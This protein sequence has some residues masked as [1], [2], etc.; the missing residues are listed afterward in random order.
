LREYT[1]EREHL[2]KLVGGNTWLFGEEFAITLNEVGLTTAVAELTGC[3]A[4]SKHGIVTR[5][6][7]RSGRLDILLPRVARR[8]VGDGEL[9]LI[10]ELK[11]PSH[12]LAMKDYLQVQSYAN[13]LSKHRLFVGT[14]TRWRFWLI[15]GSI[16]DD[17]K[18]QVESPDRE[19]GCAHR[20]ENGEIWV[21]GWGQVIESNLEVMEFY[22][23]R[24]DLAASQD[25]I[26]GKLDEMY[27]K[28]LPAG[29]STEMRPK[30]E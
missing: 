14:K 25:D 9:H 28:V 10:V 1:K 26:R 17:L 16:S 20:F 22:R 5:N 23:S 29:D 4:D 15:G 19:F 21:K 3:H 6:D 13:A 8:S 30:K 7:G 11:R 27:E 24:L 12:A 18:F 2:H